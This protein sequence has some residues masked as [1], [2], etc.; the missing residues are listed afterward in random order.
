MSIYK[1]NSLIAGGRQCMPLLSFMW[2]DHVLNDISWLRA[3]TFSWQSGA[4]YQAAYQ[5]LTADITGKTLQSETVAGTT[6]QFYLADDRH[7]ICPASEESNVT[8]IYNAT[9]VAWYYIIDTTN[10]RFKLPRTKFGFT[11]LRDTVGK[12]VAAGLPDHNHTVS[13]PSN[14]GW[15]GNTYLG[16]SDQN[17]VQKT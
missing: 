12:Y 8:A 17:Y 3:D 9:G 7:K 11:G 1:G 10:Q 13:I 4:V 16:G 14:Y 5:H 6:I 2:A 15:A